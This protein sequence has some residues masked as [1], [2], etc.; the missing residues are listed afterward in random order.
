MLFSSSTTR[1]AVA[2]IRL[3]SWRRLP[4]HCV[5]MLFGSSAGSPSEREA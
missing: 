2:H 4:A 5:S 1:T 3:V